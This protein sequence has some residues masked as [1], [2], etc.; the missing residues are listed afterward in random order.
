M[1][2][3]LPDRGDSPITLSF[4][5]A[6]LRQNLMTLGFQTEDMMGPLHDLGAI[7]VSPRTLYRLLLS[8]K[9]AE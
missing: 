2:L 6:D 8:L 1:P 5:A 4:F 9:E 7:T 3:K